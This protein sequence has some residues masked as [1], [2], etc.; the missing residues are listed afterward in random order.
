MSEN[1]EVT[2][3]KGGTKERQ[4]S[5]NDVQIPNLWHFF[6]YLQELDGGIIDLDTIRKWQLN[7][8]YIADAI[9]KNFSLYS[10]L[11]WKAYMLF[12]LS[13]SMKALTDKTSEGNSL[14]VI[15]I[16]SSQLFSKITLFS[17]DSVIK[18][19]SIYKLY[20]SVTYAS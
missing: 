11:S 13:A 8:E 4:V 3:S 20:F 2:L 19:P 7:G 6:I 5:I 17:P 14:R 9:S 12:L 1:T 15:P 18:T 10:D 16:L